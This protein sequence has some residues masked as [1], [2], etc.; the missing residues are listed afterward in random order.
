MTEQYI[1]KVSYQALIKR[2]DIVNNP[3]KDNTNDPTWGLWYIEKKKPIARTDPRTFV[4][5]KKLNSDLRPE[6]GEYIHLDFNEP[7]KDEEIITRLNNKLKYKHPDF[8]GIKEVLK[9]EKEGRTKKNNEEESMI[10]Y[11]NKDMEAKKRAR[12]RQDKI[13][14]SEFGPMKEVKP[15]PGERYEFRDKDGEIQQGVIS[16]RKE[17]DGHK[18]EDV[19]LIVRI[20][21]PEKIPAPQGG[22][23]KSKKSKKSKKPKKSKKSKTRKNSRKTNRRR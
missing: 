18:L 17:P 10:D 7:L 20:P 15:E 12:E 21:A 5:L 11:L 22:K 6:F 2:A 1:D 9:K 13:D 14:D 8:D 16:N 3:L 19:E 4:N 23:R